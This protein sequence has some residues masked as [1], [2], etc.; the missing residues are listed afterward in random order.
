MSKN[1]YYNAGD[2]NAI[3]DSCGRKFKASDLKKRWDGLYVCSDDWEPRHSL[4]FVRSHPDKITV[5]W[6][7]PQLPM[8]FSHV[9]GV[10]DPITITEQVVLAATFV[11]SFTDSVSLTDTI[12]PQR[13]YVESE[14]ITVSESIAKAVSLTKI[15]GISL[16][17]YDYFLE[18]YLEN[19]DDYVFPYFKLDR[20]TDLTESLALSDQIVFGSNEG[21]SDSTSLTESGV[22]T[23]PL[24]IEA[25]YFESEYVAATQTF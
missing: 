14:S 11:R 10:Y 18:D 15:D 7:R 17:D 2:H 16:S 21:V 6:N 23:L 1:W 25:T 19:N 20:G 5:D 3:C 13:T 22:I 8:V 4:D 24:Y 12:D 9:E